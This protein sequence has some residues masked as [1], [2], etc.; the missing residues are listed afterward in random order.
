MN[1]GS[2]ATRQLADFVAASRWE[3]IPAP[4]RHEGMRSLLNTI[5]CSL[6]GAGDEAMELAIRALGAYFGPAQARVIGRKE[7]PDALHA[8]FLNA[9]SAN[10]LEYDDTH[11]PT[12]MHPAA[13]IAPALFALADRQL[14]SGT[15]LL[16]AFILGVE[17]GCRV[18][19][20]LMPNHYR[21]GYHITAS[22]GIFSAAA[23]AAKLLGLDAEKTR[24]ALG[25]AAT[26]SA[27]LV[28]SLGSMSKSL[29]V[30][31][32]AK[33]GLTGA[34]LAAEGF[35]AADQ[36]IEGR[37]GFARVTSET[38]N[39]AAIIGGLGDEL[40][41]PAKRLQALPVRG[42]AVP[43]HRRLPRPACGPCPRP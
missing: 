12:V 24:W 14:V 43:R 40:G 21:R 38:V 13:P 28:E 33:N 26:Q 6:G 9:I 3:D 5:G 42:R 10:V 22:C 2:G 20:A 34:L 8:A 4:V 31:N 37:Y 35:T 39:L 36:A 1:A 32:A 30:G 18:G 16:H 11:L 19:N 15:Q 41:N 25:H 7:R 23:G 17:A 29:G 27:G